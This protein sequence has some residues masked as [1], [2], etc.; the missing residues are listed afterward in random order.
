MAKFHCPC[1]GKPYNGKRCSHCYYEPYTD[2]LSHAIHSKGRAVDG[3]VTPPASAPAGQFRRPSPGRGSASRRTRGDG[4]TVKNRLIF[5]LTLVLVLL[6]INLAFVFLTNQ[7][8]TSVSRENTTVSWEITAYEEPRPEPDYSVF[9]EGTVLYDDGQIQV[10]TNWRP[11]QEIPM[12]LPVYARN[13]G[14]QDVTIMAEQA[15]VNH[16]MTDAGLY[17]D[18]AA[19]SEA[20]GVLSVS[21]AALA[22]VG[23][24]ECCQLTFSLLIS[25]QETYE[26]V[27]QSP[28]IT[29]SYG[30]E[31]QA[32]SQPQLGIPLYEEQDLLISY[33]GLSG[34]DCGDDSVLFAL[35]NTSE[36]TVQVYIDKCYVNGEEV[37]LVLFSQLLPNCWSIADLWT[38]AAYDELGLETMSQIQT[39]EV[40]FVISAPAAEQ[41]QTTQLLTIPLSE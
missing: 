21:E 7:A 23:I 32:F 24:T 37:S 16:F 18:L 25:E 14:Q 34:E 19:Q 15:H 22:D 36:E 5:A 35:H 20:T 29:L 8:A 10:L 9:S 17:M 13:D 3:A 38:F 41:I 31:S 27:A 1:C 33:C 11:G 28:L 30:E 6:V 2:E 4:S 40:S 12:E 26:T 39:L